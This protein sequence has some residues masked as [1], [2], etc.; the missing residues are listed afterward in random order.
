MKKLILL[1]LFIPMI[2]C[3]SELTRGETIDKMNRDIQSVLPY[4]FNNGIVWVKAINEDNLKAVKIYDVS[5]EGISV[6]ENYISKFQ[7]KKELKSVQGKKGY[8][9]SQK[10]KIISVWRY[11]HKNTLIKEI[12]INP[13][14]WE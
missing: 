13:E 1:L 11:I 14:E 3:N 9:I 2:S 10:K 7:L 5:E 8:K 4:D 12:I 6:V